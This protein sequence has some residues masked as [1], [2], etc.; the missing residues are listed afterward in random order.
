MTLTIKIIQTFI[1]GKSTVS[2]TCE[3]HIKVSKDSVLLID[4]F[5]V[6]LEHILGVPAKNDEII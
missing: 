6:N 1:Q 4:G 3:G 2:G 5:P